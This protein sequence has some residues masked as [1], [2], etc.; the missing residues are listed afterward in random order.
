MC[1]NPKFHH[2][3]VRSSNSIVETFELIVEKNFKD[4]DF[5]LMRMAVAMDMSERQLQRKLRSSTGRTPLE[6]VRTFRLSKSL[7]HLL[8]GASISDTARA[9]GFSSPA[10]F[11]SC[12]KAEYG[13]TP[14]EY[15]E[16]RNISI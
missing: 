2:V 6:I 4:S 12:F 14:T 13:R 11:V 9:V 5:D 10:Y 16:R 3:T 7:E 15:R 1:M 8:A